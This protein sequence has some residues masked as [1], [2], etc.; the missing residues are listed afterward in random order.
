MSSGQVRLE[1]SKNSSA[2]SNFW[3]HL[4]QLVLPYQRRYFIYFITL[5]RPAYN[6]SSNAISF[7]TVAEISAFFSE[8]L[9]W[10]CT[11]WGINKNIVKDWGWELHNLLTTSER[12]FTSWHGRAM[13][14]SLLC[15]FVLPPCLHVCMVIFRGMEF[16][17]SFMSVF[18]WAFSMYKVSPI[19]QA[20]DVET[21]EVDV[22]H[23]RGRRRDHGWAWGSILPS[24]STWCDWFK[25]CSYCNYREENG[26][27][28]WSWGLDGIISGF[29]TSTL[30]YSLLVWVG[31]CFVWSVGSLVGSFFFLRSLLK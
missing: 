20:S 28:G 10:L 11:V 5:M 25:R 6:E 27:W 13:K 14:W 19:A 30:P 18:L 4:K 17:Q 1:H 3:C 12:R 7:S 24:V 26:G 2:A 16:F 23:W 31:W 21:G 22:P 9:G 29:W 8:L 15:A